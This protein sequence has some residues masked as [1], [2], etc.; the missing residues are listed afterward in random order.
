MKKKVFWLVSLLCVSGVLGACGGSNDQGASGDN[1]QEPLKM[2]VGLNQAD[3][4]RKLAKEFEKENDVKVEVIEVEEAD[5]GLLKDGEAAADVIR[6][7]HDQLGQLVEA[8]AVY[9]NEK[10]ADEI[11]DTDIPMAIEA[12][13]YEDTMYGY[14]ASADAMF[15]YY[16]KRVYDE[17]DLETLDSLTAKG[18]VGLNIAEAGADYRLTPWFIANGASLYGENGDDVDGSTLNNEQGLNVLKWV[19]KAKENENI[20]AVNS[21]EISALQEGKISALFSGV[22]NAQ[23]IKEI[24]GENMGTAVYPK[25]DFGNGAVN[26]KAFSGVPIF[27]VNAATK[28]PDKAMD[29]ARFV[30]NEEAQLEVFKGISTVPSNKAARESDA[31]QSDQIAKTVSLATTDEHSVLMPKLP[32]MKNFWPNMNALLVDTYE[33]KVPE[34]DMQKKLDTLVKD[35]S[36]PV[37]E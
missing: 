35:V 23:N 20:V 22:W 14:P 6:L 32:E 9:E 30:T 31:I 21:D 11:E 13:S 29:L 2:W 3:T 4:Y 12:A 26:L 15:L 17:K 37:E 33:G 5:D 28:N 10:Y 25:A 16:D 1:S 24:L 19:G 18:K 34:A 36:K 27:V 8:G 7:P